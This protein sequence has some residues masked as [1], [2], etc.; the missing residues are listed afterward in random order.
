LLAINHKRNIIKFEFPLS[1]D[2]SCCQASELQMQEPLI[3][4]ICS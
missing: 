2:Y 1:K 4:V 3:Q